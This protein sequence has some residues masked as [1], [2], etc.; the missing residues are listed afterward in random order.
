MPPQIR[1]SRWDV[2]DEEAFAEEG[3]A[4]PLDIVEAHHRES[5]DQRVYRASQSVA[6]RSLPGVSSASGASSTLVEDHQWSYPVRGQLV[7]DQEKP[8]GITSGV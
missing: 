6:H 8:S 1:H 7:H 5:V 3:F 4:V 2:A